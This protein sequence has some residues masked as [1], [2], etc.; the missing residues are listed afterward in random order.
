[1]SWGRTLVDHAGIMNRPPMILMIGG[2]PRSGTT[3]LCD[4]L[5][6]RPSFAIMAEYRFDEFLKDLKP[7]FNYERVHDAALGF[8]PGQEPEEAPAQPDSRASAGDAS[9]KFRAEAAARLVVVAEAPTEGTHYKPQASPPKRHTARFPRA[10][11]LPEISA[12]IVRTSLGKPAARV[13]G[14]KAPHFMLTAN[15]LGV[16][17]L[18]DDVRYLFMFRNPLTQINSAV[19]RRNRAR[20]GLDEWQDASVADMIHEYRQVAAAVISLARHF[21]KSCYFV[22]YEDLVTDAFGVSAGLSEFLGVPVF[23]MRGI[24]H[25]NPEFRRVLTDEELAELETQLGPVAESWGDRALTGPADCSRALVDVLNGIPDESIVF[26]TKPRIVGT[27]WSAPQEQGG[28][29]SVGP[30]AELVFGPSADTPRRVWIRCTPFVENDL[31]RLFCRLEHNGRLLLEAQIGFDGARP[32][33]L[34]GEGTERPQSEDGLFDLGE[35]VPDAAGA[36]FITMRIANPRPPR[37]G[38]DYELGLR[39]HELRFER[40]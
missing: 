12:N 17:R 30:L 39:L 4:I 40:L 36:N 21:P 15:H 34:D 5:N 11:Q 25:A 31:G 16:R 33:V 9:A 28:V 19:N 35:I 23:S 24:T 14:S 3:L 8:A 7:I 20:T 13:I 38:A 18:F 10:R 6:E 32:V 37:P 29:W 27:G 26:D 1:M 2:V 22:K